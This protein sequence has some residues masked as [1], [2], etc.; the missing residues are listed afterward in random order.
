[1]K[2]KHNIILE[3][4]EIPVI[5]ELADIY[6]AVDIRKKIVKTLVG[7]VSDWFESI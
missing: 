5:K 1:M 7:Q 4:S 6:Y 3:R 2:T